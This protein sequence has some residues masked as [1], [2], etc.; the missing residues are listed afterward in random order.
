MSVRLSV[1]HRNRS[2]S[3]NRS[4]Q[5]LS[6]S[7][8]KSINHQ[9]IEPINHQAYQPSSPSTIKPINHQAYQPSSLSPIE[10]IAHWAYWPSSLSTIEPINHWAYRPSCLL[11]IKPIN[12][13]AYRPLSPSAVEPIDLWLRLVFTSDKNKKNLTKTPWS[14]TKFTSVNQWEDLSTL[15]LKG[16]FWIFIFNHFITSFITQSSITLKF[17][18]LNA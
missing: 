12:H 17:F 5:P 8:I 4:Y 13:W 3:Q 14:I 2:A 15:L 9:A 7:T 6:L 10:P 11:T 18:K 16:I 1:C